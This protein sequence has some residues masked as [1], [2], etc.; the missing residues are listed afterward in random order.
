MY[1]IFKS[2]RQTYFM[3][4]NQISGNGLGAPGGG[5]Q[6]S[7]EIDQ[8]YQIEF[9]RLEADFKRN[10]IDN[11]KNNGLLLNQSSEIETHDQIFRRKLL[12]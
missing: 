11:Y 12:K 2:D 7:P 10:K 5:D 3:I 1:E 8:Q 4:A 9:D 6:V